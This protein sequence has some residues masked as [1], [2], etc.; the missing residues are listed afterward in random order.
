[1]DVRGLTHSSG[2]GAIEVAPQV[3]QALAQGAAVV[4]LESTIIDRK[5]VV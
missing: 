3:A 1:M 2:A 5:S 4:A